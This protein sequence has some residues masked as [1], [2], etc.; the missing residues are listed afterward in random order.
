MSLQH[1]S[2]L[3][4]YRKVKL[5]VG[6]EEYFEHINEA[7]SRLFLKFCSGTYGL[8]EELGKHTNRGGSQECPDCGD[9][10]ESVKHVLF[11]CASY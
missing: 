5:E 6:F 3:Q 11:K 9:C 8:V 10:K 7:S 4:V 2:K 1:K